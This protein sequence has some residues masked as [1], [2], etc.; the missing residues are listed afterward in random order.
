MTAGRDE[1]DESY[2]KAARHAITIVRFYRAHRA[3]LRS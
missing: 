1:A 2:A 3:A